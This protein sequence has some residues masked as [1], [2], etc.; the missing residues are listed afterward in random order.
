MSLTK[1]SNP[2]RARFI[3]YCN[4]DAGIYT[5]EMDGSETLQDIV[6]KIADGQCAGIY[7]VLE[8]NPVENV[9]RDITEDVLT[10]A[11]NLAREK[12]NYCLDDLPDYDGELGDMVMAFKD[13]ADLAPSLHEE[14]GDW[15]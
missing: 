14:R 6:A 13:N 9:C 7:E 11:F 5:Y 15:A 8:C 4:I 2:D 1:K 3:I 10:D 12:A